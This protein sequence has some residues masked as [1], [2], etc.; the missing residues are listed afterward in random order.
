MIFVIAA[1]IRRFLQ[2]RQARSQ[3]ASTNSNTR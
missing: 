2:R 1:L 3:Q